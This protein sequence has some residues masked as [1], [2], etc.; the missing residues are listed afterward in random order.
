MVPRAGEIR[1]FTG[2]DDPYEAPENPEIHIRTDQMTLEE[3]VAT[4]VDYL[5]ANGILREKYFTRASDRD[6][7]A[8]I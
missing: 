1:N 5:F 3:E 7:A 2:I 4:V 6:A 8:A